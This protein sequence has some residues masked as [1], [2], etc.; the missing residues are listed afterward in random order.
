[1]LSSSHYRDMQNMM[2]EA[3][4]RLRIRRQIAE[5]TDDDLLDYVEDCFRQ[6]KFYKNPRLTLKEVAMDLGITQVKLKS[7][8]GA[9]SAL[10]YFSDYITDLRLSEACFLL[11]DK[12]NF[13]IEAVANEAGFAS[14][15]TFQTRFKEKFGMTPSQYRLSITSPNE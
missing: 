7:L 11:K 5:M 10:G 12:K 1:M 2:D 15:K 4:E 3:G 6:Q 8:F 9:D 13:T 14:R